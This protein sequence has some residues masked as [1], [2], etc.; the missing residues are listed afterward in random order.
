MMISQSPVAPLIQS[1]LSAT[2]L[3]D[4]NKLPIVIFPDLALS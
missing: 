1:F 3:A 4:S 2:R